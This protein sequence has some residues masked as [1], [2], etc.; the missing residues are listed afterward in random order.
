MNTM[1]RN[2]ESEYGAV[3][4]ELDG[5]G[6]EILMDIC[7]LQTKLPD[8]LKSTFNEKESQVKKELEELKTAANKDITDEMLFCEIKKSQSEAYQ[9]LLN[10]FDK[11]PK[12]GLLHVH[13]TVG[14]DADSLLQMIVDWNKNEKTDGMKIYY[15]RNKIIYYEE[16]KRKNIPEKTIMFKEQFDSISADKDIIMVTDDNIGELKNFIFF[17]KKGN[18]NEFNNIFCRTKALFECKKFYKFYH[19]NFFK[20]CIENK[21][22]YVEIRTGF[23]EFSVPNEK[24]EDIEGI[25]KGIIFLRPDF[26]VEDFFYHE[27]M[28]TDTNPAAP[29]I[30]FLRQI[31]LARDSAREMAEYSDAGRFEVKVILT[32]NRNIKTDSKD[33]ENVLK[34]MDAAIA[35]K[36][37]NS[38]DIPEIVGFDFVSEEKMDIGTTDSFK[39]HIY[40]RFGSGYSMPSSTTEMAAVI[41]KLEEKPRIQLIR[42]FLHDGESVDKIENNSDN[43]ITGPICSRHRIGHGFKMG[44]TEENF[45]ETKAPE[46]R[47]KGTLIAD[48]ILSG[49]NV[50]VDEEKIEHY[51]IELNGEQYIRKDKIAEPVIEIC[52]ISNQLLGYTVNLN[53]HPAGNLV[54][55]GIFAVVSNDDPQI[56]DN[57]GLSYDYLMAFISGILDYEQIKISVFLGYFYREMSN[58]YYIKQNDIWVVEDNMAFGDEADVIL[59]AIDNFKGDW[60]NFICNF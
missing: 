11:M 10:K 24:S 20:A 12:G 52:P 47:K 9:V 7:N 32:A 45:N 46:N 14:L 60:N 59:K 6:S 54:K 23:Q 3:K 39:E 15:S 25:R 41:S 5:H 49:C 57:P 26:A 27:N 2:S 44:K 48:Y 56:F 31:K 36:N 51:P 43:A 40:S 28:M 22:L 35:I 37:M 16:G 34:K 4:D 50:D 55:K 8:K 13:S 42:F 1:Y 38:L 17:K 33:F 30:E 21:I 19:E 58:N 18:W 53:M 29:D